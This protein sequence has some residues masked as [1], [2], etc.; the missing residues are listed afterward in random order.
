[1]LND[2]ALIMDMF[3]KQDEMKAKVYVP[4][5]E[6]LEYCSSKKMEQSIR[7]I[8]VERKMNVQTVPVEAGWTSREPI[9]G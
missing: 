5:A 1:M 8:D 4:E 9:S 2:K 6:R 7:I 3:P